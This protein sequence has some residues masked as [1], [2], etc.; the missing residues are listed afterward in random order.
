MR[1]FVL[2]REPFGSFPTDARPFDLNDARP[3]MLNH[4]VILMHSTIGPFGLSAFVQNGRAVCVLKW[5]EDARSSTA[6]SC[7]SLLLIYRS[8]MQC[9]TRPH[10]QPHRRSTSMAFVRS[11]SNHSTSKTFGRSSSSVHPFGLVDVRR[12]SLRGRSTLQSRRPFTCYQATTVNL[13]KPARN[14]RNNPTLFPNHHQQLPPSPPRSPSFIV[15][16]GSCHWTNIPATPNEDPSSAHSRSG[17][18]RSPPQSPRRRHGVRRRRSPLLP[19]L[20]TTTGYG[21]R[22][23]HCSVVAIF[24]SLPSYSSMSAHHFLIASC[25]AAAMEEGASPRCGCPG[26]GRREF[27]PFRFTQRRKNTERGSLGLEPV[28]APKKS[29]KKGWAVAHFRF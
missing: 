2:Y 13:T 22:R 5:S 18:L 21:G 14:T 4:S 23:Y 6:R 3:L 17:N 9:L 20:S 26:L 15:N 7:K 19:S 11:A 8:A 12:F 10:F 24:F 25:T 29:E 16:S 27:A 1:P 28:L